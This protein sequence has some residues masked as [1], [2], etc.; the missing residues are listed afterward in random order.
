[1]TFGK[2]YE[3]RLKAQEAL[4]LNG[5]GIGVGVSQGFDLGD[6]VVTNALDRLLH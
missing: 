5:L 3:Q 1:L 6:K 2:K 4:S